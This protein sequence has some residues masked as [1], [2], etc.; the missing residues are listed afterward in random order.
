MYVITNKFTGFKLYLSEEQ[1]SKFHYTN[2]EKFTDKYKIKKVP[3]LKEIINPK[4]KEISV[5]C[6]TVLFMTIF[7]LAAF[8]FG[9]K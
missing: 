2:Y 7:T 5:F 6:M 8:Y 3:T 1:Y 4:I 9:F